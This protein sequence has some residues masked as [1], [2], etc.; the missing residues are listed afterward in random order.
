MKELISRGTDVLVI[1]EHWL[2]PFQ[3]S[4][5]HEVHPEY[6][7]MAM[8][9]QR[10]SSDSNERRGCGGVAIMWR[11]SFI[12]TPLSDINSDRI[13]AVQLSVSSSSML[14]IIG[15]YM[16]SSDQSIAMY[17]ECLDTVDAI[18]SRLLLF[19]AIYLNCHLGCLGGVRS[20][21]EPNDRASPPRPWTTLLAI[22]L[23]PPSYSL[24][25]D[26]PLNTSDHL[27]ISAKY[28]FSANS[29]VSK[30]AGTQRLD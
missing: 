28:S 3:L 4:N 30:V 14:T 8:S 24:A 23:A 6:S 2:W 15:I 16:P 12:T 18:I 7:Y 20:N 13:C 22:R 25:L 21:D 11:K 19:W 17:T 1:Q 5:L 27:P 9:D 26:H 10:L 29:V